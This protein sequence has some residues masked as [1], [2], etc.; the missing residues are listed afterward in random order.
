MSNLKEK[1]VFTR[2]LVITLLLSV[3]FLL[4]KTSMVYAS[5]I[6]KVAEEDQ[7]ECQLLVDEFCGAW[8][9]GQY[10]SMYHALS[11]S[12]MGKMDKD[13]F[14]GTYKGSKLIDCS[15]KEALTKGDNV[16]VKANL[17]FQ[18]EV[19]PRIIS[20]LHTFNMERDEGD[21]KIK[22][23]M[24]PIKAPARLNLPGGSHPGE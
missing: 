1:R 6:T 12:G 2:F 17:K 18:T 21:W 13:K 8:M 16:L 5:E 3:I 23:I 20:G 15:L 14:I 19:P 9:N 11:K 4:G 10:E 22:Y 24:P 7:Q